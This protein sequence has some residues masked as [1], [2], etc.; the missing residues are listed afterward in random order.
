MRKVGYLDREF[1]FT[2]PS[3]MRYRFT[4]RD[5]VQQTYMKKAWELALQEFPEYAG[6]PVRGRD[7]LIYYIDNDNPVA[8]YEEEEFTPRHFA[9]AETNYYPFY[10]SWFENQVTFFFQ[11]GTADG[12]ALL[13]FVQNILYHYLHEQGI[14]VPDIRTL[15]PADADS[16][17]EDL[18]DPLPLYAK[19]HDNMPNVLD[20]AAKA[21]HLPDAADG[22]V[23]S[24]TLQASTSQF[25][26]YTHKVKTSFLPAFTSLVSDALYEAYDA[27]DEMIVTYAP[28]SMR[29]YFPTHNRTNF[30][31]FVGMYLPND[32]KEK[33]ETKQCAF[34]KETLR[35]QM[36]KEY[37]ENRMASF[38]EA[39]DRYL[40]GEPA[41]I[42]QYEPT[43]YITYVGRLDLP[44]EY[45][46]YIHTFDLVSAPIYGITAFV[47]RT[48]GESFNIYLG[49]KA[50]YERICDALIHTFQT[51]GL[52]LKLTETEI[53]KENLYTLDQLQE[54][55]E[56]L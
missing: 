19:R 52:E 31:E 36:T 3:E 46:K 18:Y 33:D 2:Q 56:S 29:R 10:I 53:I 16:S 27:K 17:E 32:Q 20:C 34:F 37:F 43:D 51:H 5:R 30:I 21:Y 23:V 24:C 35:S 25:L 48:S 41:K 11:H 13:L 54:M 42:L 45:T 26:A 7:G 28:A 12:G 9:T 55:N 8:I 44:Q 14:D 50:D 38:I 47:L 49:T 15:P 39:Q 40:R 6:Q 4:L 22:E 1:Y